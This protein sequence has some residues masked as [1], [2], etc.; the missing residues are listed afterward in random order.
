[1]NKFEIGNR[2]GPDIDSGRPYS[3]RRDGNFDLSPLKKA[4]VFFW[5]VNIEEGM[6]IADPHN[7]AELDVL[8][9]VA[10]D[11]RKLHESAVLGKD[12]EGRENHVLMVNPSDVMGV[13]RHIQQRL[14]TN[15]KFVRKKI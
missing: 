10:E 12:E 8:K 15:P 6:I 4:G 7:Q 5:S 13:A 3:F 9:I 14:R 2:L 1:M 11:K